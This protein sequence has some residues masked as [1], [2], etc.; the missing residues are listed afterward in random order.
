MTDYNKFGFKIYPINKILL[1]TVFCNEKINGELHINSFF[2]FVGEYTLDFIFIFEGLFVIFLF[3]ISNNTFYIHS[4][5]WP[6]FLAE[7]IL[8]KP[9]LYFENKFVIFNC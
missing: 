6:L 4:L 9:D 1:S 5:K 7:S 2:Y 8:L 3:E